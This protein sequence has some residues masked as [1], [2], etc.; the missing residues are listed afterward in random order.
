MRLEAIEQLA[1]RFAFDRFTL[2]TLHRF[3]VISRSRR[4]FYTEFLRAPTYHF[5]LFV[6]LSLPGDFYTKRCTNSDW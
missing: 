2:E 1:R 6:I 4:S 3:N 5:I